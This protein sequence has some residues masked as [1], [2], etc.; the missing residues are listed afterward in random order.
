MRTRASCGL[1]PSVPNRLAEGVLDMKRHDGMVRCV[2]GRSS[3]VETDLMLYWL[4]A[5][6]LVAI[7]VLVPFALL[8]TV[9]SLC[10][11]G[12]KALYFIIRSV[13]NTPAIRTGFSK[14]RL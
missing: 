8:Y 2:V 12:A 13:S 6:A 14:Q 9:I 10:W 5:Y 3:F 1:P 4:G 11:L 7:V